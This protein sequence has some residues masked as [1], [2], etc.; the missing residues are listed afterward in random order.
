[1]KVGKYAL[2]KITVGG[3]SY[4][5]DV[6]VY[7]DRV[8]SSWWRKEGHSLNLDD[9]RDV[10]NEM[11]DVVIIGTGFYGVMK[12]PASLVKELTSRGIE[13]HVKTTAEA[14]KLFNN[15]PDRKKTIACFHLTC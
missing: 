8:D 13:V 3:K 15:M 1:M 12:V 2:G 4:I 10:L 11:P 5:S 14:I 6:I 9:L 7:P